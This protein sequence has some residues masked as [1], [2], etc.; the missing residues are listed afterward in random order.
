MPDPNVFSYFPD[1]S[2]W[3]K[4]VTSLLLVTEQCEAFCTLVHAQPVH[5]LHTTPVV[6]HARIQAHPL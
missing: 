6:E 3:P 1:T 4:R 5:T 2:V